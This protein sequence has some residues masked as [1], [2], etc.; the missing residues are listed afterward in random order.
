MSCPQA[1]SI[2]IDTDVEDYTLT[3][4]YQEPLNFAL[5]NILTTEC[6]LRDKS[7][8]TVVYISNS[9]TN[10]DSEFIYW[11]SSICFLLLSAEFF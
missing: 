3:E 10:T 8:K 4:N 1:D 11:V 5:L 7:V 9:L 6:G 2:D